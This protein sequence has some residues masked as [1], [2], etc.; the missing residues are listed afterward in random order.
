MRRHVCGF[1][2]NPKEEYRLQ[3]SFV[4]EDIER[5]EETFQI[6]YPGGAIKTKPNEI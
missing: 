6:V 1:F 3:G 5:G 4:I 2:R